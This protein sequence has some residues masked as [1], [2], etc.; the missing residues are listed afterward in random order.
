MKYYVFGTIKRVFYF[1]TTKKENA[2]KE[3][4]KARKYYP[5][6]NWIIMEE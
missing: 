2:K 3:L 4:E 1:V 5:L 6:E